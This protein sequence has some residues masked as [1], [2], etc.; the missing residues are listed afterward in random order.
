MSD[1]KYQYAFI[2]EDRDEIISI[3][4][5]NNDNRRQYKFRCI[6]CGQELLPRAVDSKYKQPHFYHKEIVNCSGETYLHKLAKHV[7]KNKFDTE[8]TFIVEYDVTEEC[9]A[10]ECKY[11]NYFCKRVFV[12]YRI[13]LKKYYDTCTEE[14]PVNGFVAD[15]LLTD[16]KNPQR[17]PVLIEVCVTHPCD[18]VKLN[19]GL[20]IIEIKIR[21]E[22]D[23]SD[24]HNMKEIR[25][26]TAWPK[27]DNYVKFISF[28]KEFSSKFHVNL[29]RY[30]Y[31]P[32]RNL[33]GYLTEVDCQNADYKLRTDSFVE[34]NVVNK[35]GI[36][37]CEI[38]DMLLW[39]SK[40]NGLKRC[41]LCKFYYAMYYEQSAICRLSNKNMRP[42]H[43]SMDEAERCKYYQERVG[44]LWNSNDFSIETA[45]RQPLSNKP[46][47][48]VIIAASRSFSNY[49]FFKEKTQYFLSNIIKNNS[50]V[51]ISGVSK[52]SDMLIARLS[53]DI[54]FVK[55][56]YET[57]WDKYGQDKIKAIN[58]SNEKMT[59]SADALIAFWDGK[60]VGIKNLIEHAKQ[61]GIKVKVIEYNKLQ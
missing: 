53:E 21:D 23:I 29:Q 57:D 20:R 30:I 50:L 7:I 3:K 60:S 48:K 55:E 36:R 25:E 38:G 10:V 9:N 6:G 51:I 4:D 19:S 39:M 59:S 11:R 8:P 14:A 35:R 37:R 27:K 1:I 13:D 54:M 52:Q 24:L 12:P 41:N 58:E 49:N 40:Y 42:A 18:E 45:I 46:E 61:K 47:Y 28:Q 15:L 26:L 32:N 22:K 44:G 43:P 31:I 56:P 34:L 17:E 5:I 16:S 2:G 33:N